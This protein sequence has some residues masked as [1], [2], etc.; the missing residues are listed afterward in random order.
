MTQQGLRNPRK[1]KKYQNRVCAAHAKAKNIKTGF[2]QPAQRQKMSKQG[3]RSSRKAKKIKTGFA[4]PA[5]GKKNPNGVCAARARRSLE[6]I[7]V[8]KRSKYWEL[9]NCR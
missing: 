6:I 2:A 4:Q 9:R 8:D 1:G 3:L 7:G 5:Q